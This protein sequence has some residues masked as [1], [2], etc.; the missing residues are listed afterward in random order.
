M[1]EC[2]VLD[3]RL[4]SELRQF[5]SAVPARSLPWKK[6]ALHVQAP[7][8]TLSLIDI[9]TTFV[10]TGTGITTGVLVSW[11]VNIGQRGLVQQK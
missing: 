8:I 4:D 1:T 11:S 3:A 9:T 10:P 6:R 2:L 7:I 5:V